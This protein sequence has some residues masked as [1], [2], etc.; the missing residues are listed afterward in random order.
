MYNHQTVWN[1]SDIKDEFPNSTMVVV[2]E[3]DEIIPHIHSTQQINVEA[4]T[5]D[6]MLNSFNL[7]F[8][9]WK[10]NIEDLQELFSN[11]NIFELYLAEGPFYFHNEPPH[12]T[13]MNPTLIKLDN[14]FVQDYPQ[15]RPDPVNEFSMKINSSKNFN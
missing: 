4:H 12:I 5:C 1:N 6:C 10:D 13:L 3:I 9:F 11:L 15:F 7:E 2:C 8:Y 14:N